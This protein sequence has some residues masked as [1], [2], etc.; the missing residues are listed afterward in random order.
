[1]YK[2]GGGNREWR[3]TLVNIDVKFEQLCDFIHFQMFDQQTTKNF[4]SFIMIFNKFYHISPSQY[5]HCVCVL[6]PDLILLCETYCFIMQ[7][8]VSSVGLGGDSATLFTGK[9]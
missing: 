4:G 7:R 3:K 1:M 6:P 8:V 2:I 5:L 9:W